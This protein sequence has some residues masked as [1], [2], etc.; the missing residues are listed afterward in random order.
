M[1]PA[2]RRLT[3]LIVA[4]AAAAII[5][6]IFGVRATVLLVSETARP[7]A[8]A[9]VV[10]LATI[11]S[12]EL[13]L[14]TGRFVFRAP[15]DGNDTLPERLAIGFASFGT[16]IAIAS[17]PGVALAGATTGLTVAAAAFGVAVVIRERAPAVQP[18]FSWPLA[19][20]APPIVV[21][22][23]LAIA[24]VNSPDE[25][26]Y[27]LAVPHAYQLY[28]RVLEMPWS[29]HSYLVLSLHFTDLAALILGGGIA[30][31]LA[32]FVLYLAALRIVHRAVARR[33]SGAA[34]WAAAILAWTPALAVIAGWAWDEWGV[35][36]LV[37]LAIDRYERW[38]DEGSRADAAAAFVAAG[39]AAS[40]KYTALPFLLALAIIV[41]WRDRR[42]SKLL[43][44]AALVTALFGS[45]FYIRN[46]IWT[47]SPV[48]P[49]MLPDAP[50]L[51]HYRAPGTLR[52]WGDFFRGEYVLDREMIDESAGV[53]LPLACI[54]GLLAFRKSDRTLRDWA[55]LGAIQLPI[56][57]SMAPVT[58]NLLAAFT[59]LALAGVVVA[60]DW[61]QRSRAIVRGATAVVLIG[62]FVAQGSVI[63]SVVESYDL[64]PYLTGRVTGEQ[65]IAEARTFAR[66]YAWI[67]DRTSLSSRIFLLGEN[68]T[69]YLGRPF[70]AAGNFDGPRIAAWLGRFRSAEALDSELRREGI[71]HVL[72]HTPWYH[73]GHRPLGGL[74]RESVLEVPPAT[75]AILMQFLA[76]RCSLRYR[77][78]DYLV[79]EIAR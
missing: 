57:I 43:V 21:A 35:V 2:A 37:V 39:C 40:V 59:P 17:A 31:K 24:P 47:G 7:A 30:A 76:T 53:L 62:A 50:P 74:E 19:L 20:L 41:V 44:A 69:F 38:H 25:L 46:A 16:L 1:T 34:I 65:Y 75:H 79:Y 13:A 33:A 54:G 66:P 68:R 67:A 11:G 23:A 70:I 55:L 56:V 5:L 18:R 10:L 52:A 45:F 61:V 27:K 28:G 73:V 36:A 63:A 14:R 64:G 6:S 78:R 42:D 60:T 58:R 32:H 77:D 12:G 29:S 8:A 22:L 26:T 4:L 71:T 15:R 3:V 48:A 49:L 72:V 51:S 9:A